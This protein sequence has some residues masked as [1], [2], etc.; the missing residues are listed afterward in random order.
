VSEHLDSLHNTCFDS[1]Y[2]PQFLALYD[3]FV[4]HHPNHD[5]AAFCLDVLSFDVLAHLRLPRLRIAYFPFYYDNDLVQAKLNRTL[6]EF[7]WTLTPFSLILAQRLYPSYHFYIYVDAD[8]YFCKSMVP[9]HDQFDLSRKD[10][11]LTEHGYDHNLPW[12]SFSGRFCV[13]YISV[14]AASGF[15]LIE[16]WYQKCLVWC[17]SRYAPDLYGDQKY[18][19]QIYES[20]SHRVYI[21]CDPSIFQ[22]PWNTYRFHP[23]SAYAYHF[24]GL[25]LHRFHIRLSNGNVSSQSIKHF[26]EPYLKLILSSDF[27]PSCAF[28]ASFSSFLTIF[29]LCLSSKLFPA[30]SR[31]HSFM[32]QRRIIPFRRHLRRFTFKI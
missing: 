10:I 17:Y 1:K 14:R 28:A 21:P 26:Y 2:L 8:M 16:Q 6:A 13:Q 19:E 20:H 31:L 24:H 9:L 11:L 12:E 18:L 32:R 3:S 4:E 7:I 25:R 29:V 5:I 23:A 22:G 30:G 27:Y 15:D